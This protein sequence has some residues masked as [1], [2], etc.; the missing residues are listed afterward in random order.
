M[1]RRLPSSNP[2]SNTSPYKGWTAKAVILRVKWMCTTGSRSTQRSDSLDRGTW[3]TQRSPFAKSERERQPAE[4]D[5]KAV[6]TRDVQSVRHV[7]IVFLCLVDAQPP[8]VVGDFAALRVE[9]TTRVWQ[10]KSIQSRGNRGNRGNRGRI[11]VGGVGRRD[12]RDG[13]VV[14][15]ADGNE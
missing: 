4:L 1:D 15:T 11:G 2:A 14:D 8:R 5:W 12:S 13:G 3:N 7:L 9:G 10:M 6:R